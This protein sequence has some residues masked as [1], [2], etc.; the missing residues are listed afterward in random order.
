L[1]S[2]QQKSFGEFKIIMTKPGASGAERQYY[3]IT[4]TDVRIASVETSISE[5]GESSEKISLA[6][7][8]INIVYNSAAGD[9]HEIEYD[10]VSGV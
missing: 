5:S 7:E 6:Y 8:K 1:A 4:L 2:F 3:T 10:V 9:E